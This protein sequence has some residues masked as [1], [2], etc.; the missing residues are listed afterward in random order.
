MAKEEIIGEWLKE[1]TMTGMSRRIEVTMP[2]PEAS[3]ATL[4]SNVSNR[5]VFHFGTR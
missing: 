3:R 5:A 4:T 1:K 2:W